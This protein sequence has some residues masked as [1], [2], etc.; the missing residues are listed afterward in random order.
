MP[1]Y[2]DELRRLARELKLAERIRF[3]GDRPDVPRL[4]AGFD[5][6]VWL[7][8]GEGMPHVLVEAGA[9]GV[10]VVTTPDVGAVDVVTD[11]ATG[12]LVPHRDPAAVARALNRLIADP[13]LRRRLG[14]NLRRQVEREWSA[15]AVVP[16]WERLFDEVI[17]ERGRG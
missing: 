8:E 6:L 13:A 10:P 7:S 17:G 16:L 12:L 3:L 14:A 4:M 9:A 15:A 2:G 5:A 1:E 11:D